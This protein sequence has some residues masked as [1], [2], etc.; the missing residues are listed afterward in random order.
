M[1]LRTAAIAKARAPG[2]ALITTGLALLVGVQFTGGQWGLTENQIELAGVVLATA[3]WLA[4]L[5]AR[6]VT[7]R[8]L[9]LDE[10]ELR[11]LATQ[12]PADVWTTDLDLRI[13]SAFGAL[14]ARLENPPARIPGRTLYEVFDTRDDTHP[15]IAAH[16]RALRGESASYERNAGD[17]VVEGR[18]EPL[19]DR[20]GRIVGCVGMV[21]DVSTWRWAESQVRRLAALV[22]SSEDAIVSTDLNGAVETWNSAAER[23]YGY[24]AAEMLG[25]PISV[26]E[27]EERAGE[28]AAMR[29]RLIRGESPPAY[30]TIRLRQDGTAIEIS[31]HLSPIRDE[32]GKLVGVSAVIRDITERRAA[33]RQVRLLADALANASD[34]ISVTDADNRF[35][36]VNEAFLR[37]YGYVREEV[38]GQTP[39]L[40]RP[41]DDVRLEILAATMQGGWTGDLVNRRKDGTEFPVSL[42]TTVIRDSEGR[43][44]GLLGVARDIT[45]RKRAEE[46]RERLAAI[47]ESSDDAIVSTDTARVIRTW[48]AGA[49]RLYGYTAAEA[50]GKNIDTLVL[51]PGAQ[52]EVDAV[53][54]R[55]ARGA[56]VVRYEGSRVRKDGS[57]VNVAA[58]ASEVRD[59]SG[60]LTGYSA[61]VRDVT[62]RRR[63]EQALRQS[64]ASFRLL[65]ENATDIISRHAPDGTFLYVS[66]ACR[67]LL[68]YDAEEL[69]GRSL[70]EFIHPHDATVTT[71]LGEA[72]DLP[73]SYSVTFRFRRKDGTYGWFESFGHTEHDQTTGAVTEIH[74]TSR[75]VTDRMLMEQQLRRRGEELRALARHLDSVREEEHTR[76]AREIHDQLG[77]A[78]T[79]LRIDLSWL[80]RKLPEASTAVRQRM[81][82]MIALADDTIEAGRNIVAELRPPIL[83]DLGLAPSLEWYVHRFAKRAGLR[84][85]WDPGPAEL[86]VD[87]EVAVIAFRIV[88]EAL[89]NV[90]RHAQAKH[91]AVRL[92]E[93]DG[94]L[95]VEIRDDGRGISDDAANSQ[96]S[97]GIVGMRERALVRGG[98]LEVRRLPGGGTSVRL[99]IL[100]KPPREPRAPR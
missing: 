72:F 21:V 77:Q 40:L 27:P 76:I 97:L 5:G 62:E 52:A 54:E 10:S 30:D 41:S 22:Q 18:V 33:E 49:E 14:L 66:P 43:I 15:A 73:K 87:R 74:A 78:L 36:Y 90:A 94:A 19:R 89:T 7:L 47:V 80:A 64:E 71:P 51:A 68:G 45:E 9:K 38:L 20:K 91:V 85:E 82:A 96:R 32:L 44:L 24:S 83:D 100:M 98:S 53:A 25:R 11:L 2:A 1:R 42:S 23:L 99:A 12:A 63:A 81:G 13:T 50:I 75:D 86:F 35:V 61:I 29:E 59:A 84:C 6:R 88:Q 3:G 28:A 70:F 58:A 17:L 4:Y 95:T 37:A 57:L 34:M 8:Q 92:G 55:L 93:Q 56:A 65:T 48:N 31:T 46:M 67:K 39:A 16:L 60:A 69:V 79:A 26:L